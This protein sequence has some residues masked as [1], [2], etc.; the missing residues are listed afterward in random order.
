MS[1]PSILFVCIGNSARSQMAEAW[2]CHLAGDQFIVKSGGTSPIPVHHLTLEAMKEVGIDLSSATSRS[3]FDFKETF[4]YVVTTCAEAE[5]DCPNIRGSRGT[6]HWHIPDPVARAADAPNAKAASDAFRRARELV[7][8][9]VEE[10]LA[11]I[12]EGKL[13]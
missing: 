1:K 10:L 12:H 7:K 13:G 11:A 5:V 9:R 8:S 4:D 3:V 6:V 2:F